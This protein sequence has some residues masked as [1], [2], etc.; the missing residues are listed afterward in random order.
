MNIETF[1]STLERVNQLELELS[2]LKDQL[3]THDEYSNCE[4]TLLFLGIEENAYFTAEEAIRNIMKTMIFLPTQM[5]YTVSFKSVIRIGSCNKQRNRPRP[6]SVTLASFRDREV[7]RKASPCLRNTDYAIREQFPIE[8]LNRRRL[9]TPLLRDA[10]KKNRYAVLYRDVLR[11]DNEEWRIDAHGRP[12]VTPYV[13]E[14]THS[15]VTTQQQSYQHI[16]ERQQPNEQSTSTQSNTTPQSTNLSSQPCTEPFHRPEIET[17]LQQQ[18]NEH[19]APDPT[20]IESLC[21]QQQVTTSTSATIYTPTPSQR[22]PDQLISVNSEQ[23]PSQTY[24]LEPVW[25]QQQVMPSPSATIYTP[26]PS[27]RPPDQ[28]I[29]VNSEQQHT[30]V[31]TQPLHTTA[32]S[33]HTP[34]TVHQLEIHTPTPCQHPP[35]QQEP[36]DPAPSTYSPKTTYQPELH[37]QTPINHHTPA[38]HNHRPPKTLYQLERN[39][40]IQS[41]KTT[42]Q[43]KKS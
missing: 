4:N 17:I 9:L 3:K 33:H 36:Y 43:P 2:T 8:V 40:P 6:I 34:E 42:Y 27:Q 12:Y 13:I 1:T 16:Y 23:L 29:S 18:Q 35:D 28:L 39:D 7:V 22:P 41:P 21:N 31:T 10:R 5:P 38:S 32:P 11:I 20:P 19:P 26:T 14:Q 15:T 30:A 25:N 24:Q 37:K